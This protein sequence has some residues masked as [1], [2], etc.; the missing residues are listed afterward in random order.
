MTKKSINATK[1]LLH[2]FYLNWQIK[3]SI[4]QVPLRRL[5]IFLILGVAAQKFIIIDI[6]LL[7]DR[8]EIIPPTAHTTKS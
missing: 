2:C 3:H 7:T 8:P 5:S 1:H 4:T 6:I